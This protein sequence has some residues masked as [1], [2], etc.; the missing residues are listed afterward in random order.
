MT[1]YALYLLCLTL[2]FTANLSLKFVA[3]NFLLQILLFTFLASIPAYRHGRMSYVD[4]AW[5]LGLLSMGILSAFFAKELTERSL[6]ISSAYILMGGRMGFGALLLWSKGAFEKEFPRYMYQRRVWEKKGYTNHAFVMQKELFL[7]C[8]AN[9]TFLLL[10]AL[11]HISN[12]NPLSTFEIFTFGM[13]FFFFAMESLADYQ[14]QMFIRSNKENRKKVCNV[15]LWKYSRHPN[16]FCEWMV[17]NSLILGTLSSV[18][19]LFLSQ[20]NPFIMI[21][22]VGILFIS[23][24]MYECLVNYTGARPSEYYSLQKRPEYKEYMNQTNQFFPWFPKNRI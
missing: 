24:M 22:G 3:V 8:A 17:W 21:L 18:V 13:W 20:N 15:G 9:C 11:V 16:Y 7:Q 10:P 4:I 5:P 12:P 2:I 6:L 1:Y 14:K 19:H 23:K